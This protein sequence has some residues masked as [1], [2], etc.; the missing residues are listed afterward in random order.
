MRHKAVSRRLGVKTAHRI[1][2][3]RNLTAALVEHGRIKTTTARAKSLRV[4]VEKIVTRL[5]EPSVSNI[6]VAS[7]KL[8]DRKVALKIANEVSPKFK[9]RPGGYLRILKLVNPRVGDAADLSLIEWS[10]EALV[11]HYQEKKAAPKAKAKKKASSKKSADET[12]AA[13]EEKSSKKAKK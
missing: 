13:S 9:T 4:F 5:K 11:P 3:L 2:L 6:R 7:S 12:E 1:A 8:G 10:E